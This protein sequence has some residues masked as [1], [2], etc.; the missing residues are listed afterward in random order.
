MALETN[1]C[2]C[3]PAV[4]FLGPGRGPVLPVRESMREHLRYEVTAMIYLTATIAAFLFTWWPPLYGPS[5]SRRGRR[6]LLKEGVKIMFAQT[7]LLLSPGFSRSNMKRG[8]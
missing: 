7:W 8:G 4:F 1:P 2:F 3:G 6:R 5:G